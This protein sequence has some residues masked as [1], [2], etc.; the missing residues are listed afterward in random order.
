MPLRAE[1]TK[2]FDL[3]TKMDPFLL[4]NYN[5]SIKQTNVAKK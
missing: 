5:E 4:V 2:N 3:I 1:Y